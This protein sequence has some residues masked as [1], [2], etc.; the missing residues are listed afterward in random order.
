VYGT[1]EAAALL[2]R[3]QYLDRQLDAALKIGKG[4]PEQPRDEWAES[5]GDVA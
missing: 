1:Q 3:L 5:P 4:V 2:A